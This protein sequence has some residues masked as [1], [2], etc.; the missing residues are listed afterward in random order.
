MIYRLSASTDSS[1]SMAEIRCLSDHQDQI[2]SLIN[3]NGQFGIAVNGTEEEMCFYVY[4]CIDLP[5]MGSLPVAPM[6]AS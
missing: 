2:R 4:L 5:Q 6:Q 3:V 1:L